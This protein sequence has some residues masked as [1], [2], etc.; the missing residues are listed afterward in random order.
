KITAGFMLPALP[1]VSE[2]AFGRADEIKAS[3]LVSGESHHDGRRIGQ[4]HLGSDGRPAYQRRTLQAKG[5]EQGEDAPEEALDRGAFAEFVGR[6]GRRQAS[7]ILLSF[8]VP[9]D[10]GDSV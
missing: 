1:R 8:G 4:R 7:A 5:A 10:D 6:P 9:R 3:S 2:H